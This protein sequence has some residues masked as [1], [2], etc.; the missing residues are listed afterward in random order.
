MQKNCRKCK[1]LYE[2][3]P[4]QIRKQD[5][6]CLA[7]RRDYNAIWRD[8]RRAQGLPAS[9]SKN[10]DPEKRKKW[11]AWYY[12]LPEVRARNA[13]L[14]RKYRNDPRLRMKHEAR[15]QVGHAIEAGRLKRESCKRCR[16][17]K[18]EAHHPDYYK[19]LEIVWL[20]RTCHRAEHKLAEGKG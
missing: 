18:A 8:K 12:A 9:G 3:T 6:I 5:Y 13:E 14:A 16:A 10:Y 17:V 4:Y 2:P 15:W 20:C 11:R 19:P 7:C 1:T